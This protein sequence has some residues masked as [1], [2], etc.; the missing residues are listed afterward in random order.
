MVRLPPNC[1]AFED[2]NSVTVRPKPNGLYSARRVRLVTP[3]IGARTI[4]GQ[5]SCGPIRKAGTTQAMTPQYSAPWQVRLP[6]R[7]AGSGLTA[8]RAHLFEPA[9]NAAA[10]P[11]LYRAP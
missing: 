7:W 4:G 6:S 1:S 8:E 2:T 3:D 10:R 11:N 9:S 5:I